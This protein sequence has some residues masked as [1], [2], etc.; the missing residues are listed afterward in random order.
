MPDGQEQKNLEMAG[1]TVDYATLR[2]QHP[3]V[4]EKDLKRMMEPTYELLARDDISTQLKRNAAEYKGL[5]IDEFLDRSEIKNLK[6]E[7]QGMYRGMFQ[8]S[9]IEGMLIEEFNKLNIMES[10]QKGGGLGYAW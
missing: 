8:S 10:E 5:T 9:D 4:P 6:V 1:G 7:L 3:N 2:S